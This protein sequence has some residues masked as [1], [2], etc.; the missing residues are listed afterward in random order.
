MSGAG[1]EPI[2]VP[3]EVWRAHEAELRARNIGALFRLAKQYAG[4]SQN[5]IAAATGMPQSRVNALMNRKGGPVVSIELLERIAGG[6]G[7]PDSARISLGLAPRGPARMLSAALS[8]P[9]SASTP[10]G[11]A[12]RAEVRALLAHAAEVTMGVFDPGA[13]QHWLDSTAVETPLPS[14]VGRS[15]VEQIEQITAALRASDYLYGGGACREAASAQ[16]RWVTRLLEVPSADEVRERLHLALAD[17]H[18]L[19]GWASFDVGLHSP[20][21]GHFAKALVHAQAGG[22]AS[23]VANILYR[24]GRLHLHRSMA[25]EALRFF[26]LGQI[27]A[28]DAGCTLTVALLCANEA[29]AYACLGDRS[30]ALSSLRRS[31]DELSRAD[32]ALAAPWVRF[33]GE[34][35]LAGLAGL[36]HLELA[37]ADRAHIG[38]ARD[39]LERAL[40]LRGDD[41]MVRSR[42]FEQIALA[43][44]RLRDGDIEQGVTMGREASARAVGLQSTRARDRLRPLYAAALDSSHPGAVEFAEYLKPYAR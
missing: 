36:I 12:E 24:T 23:L 6:L 22:H 40:A 16:S 7:M 1:F 5:R 27:A 8:S 14:Q 26:Q 19:A 21:R 29:W 20:A 43:T 38:S 33:F 44:A 17:L 13:D 2:R 37:A 10:D 32:T 34:P 42:T 11:V 30:Q 31:F 9:R 39:S 41:N 35:D 18:N 4:A 3:G 15:D 28:Q 25:L